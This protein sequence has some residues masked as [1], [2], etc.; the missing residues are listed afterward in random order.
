MTKKPIPTAL[1]TLSGLVLLLGCGSQ[2]SG[3]DAA[4][5][6]ASVSQTSSSSPT[7][8]VLTAVPDKGTGTVIVPPRKGKPVAPGDFAPEVVWKQDM[9][10]VTAYGS[11]TC[12]PVAEEAVAMD[13]Q[14]ILLTFGDRPD[15]VACTDDYGPTRSRVPAPSGAVDLNGD[16]YATFDLEG[17]P[18]QLIPVQLID[19][20][21]N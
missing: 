21:L 16:V 8:P 13:E 12:R 5:A 15:N 20:V 18:Q 10:I 3:G 17:T 7:S 19:P 4:G 9:L 6:A 14:T 1:A 11:S 2:T